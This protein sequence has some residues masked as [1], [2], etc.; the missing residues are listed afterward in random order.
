MNAFVVIDFGPNAPLGK[1]QSMTISLPCGDA[2]E[3]VEELT[4]TFSALEPGKGQLGV[5]FDRPVVVRFN[6]M[7]SRRI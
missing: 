2:V 1:Q 6:S 7:P 4:I 3:H 5:N